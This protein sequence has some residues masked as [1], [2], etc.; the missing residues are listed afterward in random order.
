MRRS[1][2]RAS[3]EPWGAYADGLQSSKADGR[4]RETAVGIVVEG[5]YV[6]ARP[7]GPFRPW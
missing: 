4:V 7:C 2:E 1:Q 5:R 6:G 3:Q